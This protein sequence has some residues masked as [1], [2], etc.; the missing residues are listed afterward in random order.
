MAAIESPELAALLERGE[1]HGRLE[2]SQIEQLAEELGLGEEA[3]QELY[4]ELDARGI[5]LEDDTGRAAADH[6]TWVNGDLAASTT[7]ALQLFL[8]E[9]GRYPLLTAAEEVELAKRT[10]R[11]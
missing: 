4:A 3:L 6:P 5:E 9:A 1:E 10:E 11:G 8:D 2:L 7:D